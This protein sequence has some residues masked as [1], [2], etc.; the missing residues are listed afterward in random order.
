MVQLLATDGVAGDL[1]QADTGRARPHG[2][3]V[4]GQSHLRAVS[5]SGR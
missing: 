5:V 4:I 1:Q 3:A 2:Y